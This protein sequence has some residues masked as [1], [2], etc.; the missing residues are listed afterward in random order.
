MKKG[1]KNRAYTK[2][3]FS[4]NEQKSLENMLKRELVYNFGYDNKLAIADVLVKNFL[5][6][7]EKFA[8]DKD[9]VTPGQ[10]VW[11]AI[12]KDDYPGLGKKVANT[13]LEPVIL[14]LWTKDEIEQIANG[15]K[16]NELLPDRIARVCQE[17]YSQGGLLS[18]ADLMLIFNISY[19]TAIN[20]RA[21]WEKQN[22]KTLPTRGSIHDLGLT[23]SHKIEAINL[24][25]KGYFTSE[26]ARK[27]NHDP[28][29]IDQYIKDFERVRPFVKEQ[30]P[31]YKISFFTGL[32][33]KLIKEYIKI[34]KK[35]IDNKDDSI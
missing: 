30:A 29:C 2:A 6:I 31:V 7:I 17:A 34:F 15:R 16:L 24:H 13:L 28:N 18:S 32:S 8:P 26:I 25:L 11:L 20:K 27:L 9:N 14:T 35:Y 4:A 23:F 22:N 1:F 10:I 12:S 19:N 5:S 3:L 21:L 33:Q